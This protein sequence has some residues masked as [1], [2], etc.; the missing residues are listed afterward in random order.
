MPLILLLM[1]LV[2]KI[3]RVQRAR[4]EDVRVERAQSSSIAILQKLVLGRENKKTENDNLEQPP[5]NDKLF[6]SLLTIL[7]KSY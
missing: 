5:L 1:I 4:L 7:L 6:T 2:R 3:A